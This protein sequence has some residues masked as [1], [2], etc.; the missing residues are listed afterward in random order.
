MIVVGLSEDGRGNPAWAEHLQTV[1][2]WPS[3]MV[4]NGHDIHQSFSMAQHRELSRVVA[5]GDISNTIVV[6]HYLPA[7]TNTYLPEVPLF[8]FGHNHGF[9]DTTHKS[10]RFVNVSALDNRV[11]VV[12]KGLREPSRKDFRNINRGSYVIISRDRTGLIAIE[13]E[14]FNPDLQDWQPVAGEFYPR[15]P[16]A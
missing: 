12:P 2:R 6:T 10:S 13:P 3:S 4:A 16:D 11:T 5:R 8:L 7:K 15:A 14:A 1:K 9:K